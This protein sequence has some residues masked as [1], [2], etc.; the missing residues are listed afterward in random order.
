LIFFYFFFRAPDIAEM[1]SKNF[2]KLLSQVPQLEALLTAMQSFFILVGDIDVERSVDGAA[3]AHEF[4]AF[5]A[6]DASVIVV[7]HRLE[8]HLAYRFASL[9]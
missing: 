9:D 8:T 1:S 5:R 6:S 4:A 7:C 3:L 2:P